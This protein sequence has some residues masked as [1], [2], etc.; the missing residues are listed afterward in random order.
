MPLKE[1]IY[2]LLYKEAVQNAE[3]TKAA[4]EPETTANPPPTEQLVQLPV[5]AL[6]DFPADIH[7]FRPAGAERLEQLRQDIVLNGILAPLLVR[8]LENGNYQIL[9]GHNRKRAAV[10]AHYDQVPCI[11]KDVDDADAISIMLSDNLTQREDLLPSEKARAYKMQLDNMK[12]RPGRPRNSAQTEPNLDQDAA[13]LN[14][15]TTLH[16]LESK[17]SRE[18]LAEGSGESHEQIRKYIRLNYL[19]EDLLQK[20][21]DQAI[22]LQIGCTLSYLTEEAQE[23]VYTYYF[24]DNKGQ[25]IDQS[26]ASE[27]RTIDADPA[28]EITVEVLDQL[29]QERAERRFRVVKI[30]MKGI[31]QYFRPD[32]TKEE[33]AQVIED[34][35]AFYYEHRQLGGEERW[36]N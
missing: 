14:C 33:V 4:R 6:E 15:A 21:D 35:V 18:I 5:D 29:A 34:A 26:L 2:D 19:S 31:R 1:G 8:P 13:D 32:V 17:R 25:H 22:G 11:I 7:P 24:V 10:L 36:S 28:Q 16:N 23:T 12:R 3:G 30:Q 20:V 9:A 27:L